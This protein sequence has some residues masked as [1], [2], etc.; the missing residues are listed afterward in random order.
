MKS[1]AAIHAH[2]LHP[3]IV[4]IPIGAFSLT[5][6]GDV[7]HAM[8]GDP[9]WYRFAFIS[10]G[11]GIVGALVA[12]GFGFFDYFKVRMSEQGARVAKIHMLLNLGCVTLY[13]ANF[14]MR[15]D[16]AALWTG[17]WPVVFALE[18]LTFAALGVSGWLG[19]TLAF[20]HKVGVVERL[21]PEATS[22]GMSERI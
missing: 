16:S 18:V 2:P 13:A 17:R 1:R 4:P 14:L 3:A 5:L 7:V 21:D 19:G 10:M 8:T 15:K 22:I 12:A 20:K 11:I 9:F 6:I